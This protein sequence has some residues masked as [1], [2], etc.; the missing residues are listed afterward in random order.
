M[1]R[2]L[3]CLTTPLQGGISIAINEEGSNSEVSHLNS[4]NYKGLSETLNPVSG[5][6]FYSPLCTVVHLLYYLQEN[7]RVPPKKRK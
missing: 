4:P 3:S 7:S 6:F 1:Y 5:G 2:S